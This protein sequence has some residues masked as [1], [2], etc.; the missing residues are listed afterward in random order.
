MTTISPAK[1]KPADPAE[2]GAPIRLGWSAAWRDPLTLMDG[3]STERFACRAVASTLGRLL[4]GMENAEAITTSRDPFILALNHSQ[5]LEAVV[6]PAWLA[7]LRGGRRVHFMADWNFLL[8]PG[9]GHVIRAGRSIIVGRKSAR[10]AFLNRFKSRLVPS[11]PP[12]QQAQQLLLAGH[13]VGIFVEGTTN[14]NPG[15]LLRGLTGAARLSLT[16]RTPIIPAGIVFPRHDGIR[17]IGDFEPFRIRFG[18]P[19]MPQP[20][21]TRSKTAAEAERDLHSTVM[22]AI[23]ALSGKNWN[24]ENPRTKHAN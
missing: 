9:L 17:P 10:P 7:L 8:V 12:M 23:S 6:I 13:S 5:R 24:P 14:R 21:P 3:T 11:E 1:A 20:V 16:T 19:I 2:I 22:T 4:L 18:Q 15:R